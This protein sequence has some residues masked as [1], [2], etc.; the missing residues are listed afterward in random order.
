MDI[1]KIKQECWANK[2]YSYG[3]IKIFEKRAKT[4]QTGRTWITFLGVVVPVIVGSIAMSFGAD[5]ALLK[6]FL[7]LAGIVITIQL[8]LSAWSIVSRW[9][10]K[11][12]YAMNSIGE[13]T[14]LYNEW[15]AYNKLEISDTKE[16][17]DKFNEILSR[18]QKQEFSD[19]KQNITDKEKRF[20]NRASL[21]Y[22]K[23]AC[24]VC[25][26]IPTTVSPSKCDGCGNF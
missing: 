14:R 24:S 26:Q 17:E 19:I 11:Y 5:S 3:T 10:E 13:N 8:V 6:Y 25:S 7:F 22:F 2:F 20:A 12:E 4:L 18:T 15:D 9:D 16:S 23:Q 1:E 21:F